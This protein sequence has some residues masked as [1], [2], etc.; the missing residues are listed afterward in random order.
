MDYK[1]QKLEKLRELCQSYDLP[2][3]GKKD[4]LMKRLHEFEDRKLRRLE[5]DRNSSSAQLTLTDEVVDT[6]FIKMK[7]ENLPRYINAGVIY[8]LKLEANIIYKEENRKWDQFNLSESYIPVLKFP[9]GEFQDDD[10]FIEIFSRGLNIEKLKNRS[11]FFLTDPLPISRINKIYF[12]SDTLRASFASSVKVFPDIFIP[13]TLLA[14]IDVNL[15]LGEKL[16][17]DYPVSINNSLDEWKESLARYDRILGMF[18]FMKNV[19][20]FF[21]E[22]DNQYQQY[23]PAFF[24]AL[25]I[26]NSTFGKFNLKEPGLYHYILFPEEI[27]ESSLQRILF[28]QILVTIYSN[29]DFSISTAKKIIEQIL[30]KGSAID[31]ERKEFEEVFNFLNQLQNHQATYNNIFA[32]ES[33]RK[34]YPLLALLFLCRF[35]NKSRQHTDKQAARIFFISN[36]IQYSKGL[37]EFL[38]AVLGL[39]YG[40]KTMVKEDTNLKLK[41]PYFLNLA[42]KQ[43]SIK[44]R[45]NARI[46]RV[47]IE[48]IFNWS[49]T[50]K[51]ENDPFHFLIA[52][53]TQKRELV[54]TWK[55]GGFEYEDKS[56]EILNTSITIIE[57]RSILNVLMQEIERN[58]P[59]TIS[60]SS[61]L[62]HY[63][64]H[65]LG[66]DRSIL[67]AILNANRE[68]IDINKLIDVIQ[69]DKKR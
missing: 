20:I 50:R 25:G 1:K 47:I 51:V 52:K 8:P 61:I 40:Y 67:F 13:D 45:L 7:I 30:S 53:E 69:L 39:Y 27:E 54:K 22:R 49:Q 64:I 44:F 63:L 23:T 28:K 31:P 36:E 18:S 62:A 14:I 55:W 4:D 26:I 56:L 21:S 3:E 15:N 2:T 46:D 16:E 57:R 32:K 9:H 11:L 42:N 33:I 17:T 10:V 59:P 48:S 24:S 29:E 5:F 12:K 58:Y 35:S 66:I 19:G 34:N 43:Q 37:S 6:L 41:D 68:K 60:G 65:S 38:L